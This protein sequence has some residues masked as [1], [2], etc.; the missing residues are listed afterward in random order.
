LPE[1]DVNFQY[2]DYYRWLYS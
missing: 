2:L 1:K